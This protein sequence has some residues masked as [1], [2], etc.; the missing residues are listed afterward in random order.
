VLYFMLTFSL[1]NVRTSIVTYYNWVFLKLVSRHYF[2]I[3]ESICLNLSKSV[4]KYQHLNKFFNV[5]RNNIAI[6]EVKKLKIFM[7]SNVFHYIRC[8]H[9]WSV[10]FNHGCA[11]LVFNQTSGTIKF[12]EHIYDISPHHFDRNGNINGK[13]RAHCNNT[14]HICETNNQTFPFLKNYSLSTVWLLRW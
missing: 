4:M 6:S 5:F 1:I 7:L 9:N 14:S 13:L 11:Y 12:T 10:C 2:Q 3:S 8:S